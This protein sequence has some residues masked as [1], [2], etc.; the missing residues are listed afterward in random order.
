MTPR[1]LPTL[2][3]LLACACDSPPE[4]VKAPAAPAPQAAPAPKAAPAPQAAPAAAAPAA[5]AGDLQFT[6]PPGWVAET[7]S[8][9]MRK[10]Q[11]TLP[12]AEGDAADASL[13]LYYFGSGGGGGREANLERW[14]GQFEQPDGSDSSARMKSSD[15]TVNGLAVTDVDL[16]GTYVAETA[17]GSGERVRE[18]GWRM[19]ASIVETPAGPYYAKLVGPEKT[20]AHWKASYEAFVGSFKAP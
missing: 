15:R 4:P 17:P 9:K 2:L 6:A 20:V 7:P 8:S 14:A 5:A 1:R 12:R 16:S 10:A 19:L 13:V 3:L 11:Y 18:E